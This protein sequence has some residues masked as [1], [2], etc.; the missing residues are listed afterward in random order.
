MTDVPS[1]LVP[2]RIT[3]LPEY[4][5]ASPDGYVAY[6]YGGVTYKVQLSQVIAAINVPP[7]RI[8]ATG[9][10]LTG[11]GDLTIDRT[12]A[13]LNQGVGYPQLSKTGAVAGTYGSA[14]AVPQIVVDDTGRITSVTNLSIAL[15]GYV[16]DTRQVI[17]GIGLTGGGALS[18]NVTLNVDFSDTDPEALGPLAL[19]GV[20]TTAS[21]DDHVHPAVDLSDP[22]QIQGVLP[23]GSGGTG[24]ALS[25]VA[26]AIVY[27]TDEKFALSNAGDPG[28]V[29]VS[30]GPAGAPTWTNVDA[31]QG[32]T[33]ATG[34]TGGLGPTGATGSSITG[35]T[36]ATG[37]TGA[38]STVPGPT[39]P[40]GPTGATG[41]TGAT[42]TVPGPTGPTG[43]SGP[44]GAPGG[45]ITYKGT[46]ATAALLPLLGNTTGDAYITLDTEHLWIWDG[47]AWT[48]A[49][50]VA[51]AG[52]TG[53]TGPTGP[54]GATGS[55]GA[56]STVAGPTGATG[57]TGP[58]GVTGTTGATGETGATGGTGPTGPTG[59]TGGTGPTG[60]QG[61]SSS[62]FSYKANVTSTS[63]Y[64]NDGHVLWNNATQISATQLNISHLTDDNIDIDIFLALIA[65]GQTV[66]FQDAN[67]SANYQNWYV[68]GATTNV[69]PGA[70]NSYWTVP[71][72]LTSSAGT[73]TTGFTTNQRLFIAIVSSTA[74]PTGPTGATGTTGA[75]S[76]VPG[77]T[78]PTGATGVTGPTGATGSTG[79]TSTVPGPTGPT[80]ATGS[81]GPTG[82]TGVT[83]ATGATGVTGPTGATG[84]TGA[85]GATGVTGSTGPT[86]STG[87]TG[88]TTYPGVGIAVSTGTAWGTSLA[89]PLTAT[90]GGTGLSSSGSSGNVLTSNGSGWVSS[91][92]AG[93]GTGSN[94][95]LYVNNGGF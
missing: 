20:G 46:V 26:G 10:G 59:V 43:G 25:P 61:S 74:G 23:L 78:G 72:S 71:V 27:S 84:V 51:V 11:G 95:Y 44:T 94:L 80:G 60:A 28:Q 89:D 45:G 7:S 86:G 53:V 83:G 82:A 75:T 16:L 54:T 52:P 24:D 56:T 36:G 66:T 49:G 38:T 91:V 68:T 2:T 58:T 22:D 4:Q 31:L 64:P 57:P 30:N 9:T 40:T 3:Q 88:P 12:H 21:R 17:A 48:D 76:T 15:V 6:V 65:A 39:G 90:H 14:T 50:P 37:S 47:V 69:N 32:P 41:S 85:T 13:I 33:G 5:G 81:T 63:G 1:N 62:L 87:G 29:L 77:P 8:I 42:S 18:S 73:G 79:A 34:A 93:G 70:A 67:V 35:P 19:P 92:P 55:T